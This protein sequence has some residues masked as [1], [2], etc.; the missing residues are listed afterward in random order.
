MT[1]RKRGLYLLIPI[2]L[3]LSACTAAGGSAEMPPNTPG[4]IEFAVTD[5]CAEAAD[6]QCV[7]VNGESIVLPSTFHRA[8]VRDVAVA[9]GEGQN[10]VDV[11]FTNDGAALLRTLTGQAATETARLVMKVGGEIVSAVAVM[12]PVEGDQLQ[13]SL[14]PDDSAQNIV[15][16]IRG[17]QGPIGP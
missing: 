17:A 1:S 8:G 6:S 16:L 12:E 4:A 7:S 15:D 11:T 5:T 14:S 3:A 2:L 9:E 13:I 10:A